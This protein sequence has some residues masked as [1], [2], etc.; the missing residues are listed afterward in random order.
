[1][2]SLEGLPLKAV[3]RQHAPARPRTSR[4]RRVLT[5]L[6]AAGLLATSAAVP[7]VAAAPGE[8]VTVQTTYTGGA[9]SV[10]DEGAASASVSVP[11]GTGNL[12]SMTLTLIDPQAPAPTDMF[13]A[14]YSP[15][16]PNGVK[17]VSVHNGQTT[18]TDTERYGDP[19]GQWML[20]G[21]DDF[22]TGGAGSSFGGFEL[23]L[24]TEVTAPT[25]TT[26]PVSPGTVVSGTPVTLT[27]AAT[28][29]APWAQWQVD[30]GAGF[31]DIPGA[32][33]A[34]YT[35]T[36][37]VAD[38]GFAYRVVY[39]NTVGTT[40]SAPAI[41]L[42]DPIPPSVTLDPTDAAVSSGAPVTFVS[43]GTGDP[44]PTVQ[45]QRAAPGSNAFVDLPGMTSKNLTLDAVTYA[46]SGSAFRAVYTSDA[47]QSTTQPATLTVA[48]QAPAVTVNPTDATVREGSAASFTAAASGDPAASVQWQVS[49]DGGATYV[50]IPGA[51]APTY[52][53]AASARDQHLDLFRAVFTSSAGTTTSSP[54]TLRVEYAPQILEHPQ[55]VDPETGEGATLTARADGNPTPAVQWQVS[56]DGALTF[57]DVMGATSPTLELTD[58]RYADSGTY[59]RAVFTNTVGSATSDPAAVRVYGAAPTVTAQPVDQ[60]AANGSDVTFSADAVGDPEPTVQWSVSTNGYEFREIAG[61]TSKTYTFTA[62]A[63]DD[64]NWYRADFSNPRGGHQTNT[65]RLAVTVAPVV[66]ASPTDQTAAEDAVA[67]FTSTASG[68]PAPTTQWQVSTD[69][70]VTFADIDGAVGTSLDVVAVRAASGNQ[71]RA[72]HTNSTGEVTSDAAALTVLPRAVVVAEPTDQAVVAGGTVTFTARSDDPTATIQ[73]QVSTD[74]GLTFSDLP[75]EVSTDLS[76]VA[77]PSQNGYLYRA[78]FT[79]AGGTTV[80]EANLLTVSA[81]PQAPGDTEPVVPTGPEVP[82]TP[83]T[84]GTA[85]QVGTS[86]PTTGADTARL[87]VTALLLLAGG[88]AGVLLHRRRA[89]A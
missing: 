31:T 60:V 16:F 65:A 58:Q 13:W 46:E 89:A 85:S 3:D 35:F 7:A 42:V 32:M 62:T 45:W 33:N 20:V 87:A 81:A 19:G 72:V 40:V 28:G 86:L 25:I 63:A 44:T 80:T 41:V 75:G 55:N 52:A 47:G 15:V 26:A 9:F 50:N 43:D 29:T 69:D 51:T 34:T 59:Y 30:R 56:T 53:T 6:L 64:G 4:F 5:G 12:V 14:I 39:S 54:A 76:F 11:S 66:T 70:G 88:A 38:S 17:T 57:S 8:I 22:P 83:G 73:W 61:A 24:R 71:Y 67:T 1:M 68:Q 21:W 82:V 49:T 48:A 27:S 79:T 77:T 18:F 2:A 84:P 37:K 36:P 10:P 78:V 74:G 23:T